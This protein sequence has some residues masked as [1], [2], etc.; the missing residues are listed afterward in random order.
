MTDLIIAIVFTIIAV[1]A[2]LLNEEKIA[3][4]QKENKK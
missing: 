1:I 2:L 4:W 3:N